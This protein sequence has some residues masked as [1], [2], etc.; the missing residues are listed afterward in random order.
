MRK[1]AFV[2]SSL[3]IA[4]SILSTCGVDTKGRPMVKLGINE[5]TV[6]SMS[7]RRLSKEGDDP[8]AIETETKSTNKAECIKENISMIEAFPYREK[9]EKA[10]TRQDW[11]L[12]TEYEIIGDGYETNVVF[13]GY[14]ISDGV[15][16]FVK[17]EWHYIPGETSWLFDDFEV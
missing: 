2:S 6:I 9:L 3:L 11:Y 4:S 17:G 5:A 12:K 14:G 15:V 8:S 16:S 1:S 10:P 7:I 13:I